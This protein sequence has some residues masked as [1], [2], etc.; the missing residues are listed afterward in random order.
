M[1]KLIVLAAVMAAVALGSYDAMAQCDG[2]ASDG[3]QCNGPAPGKT[4]G[5]VNAVVACVGGN[6]NGPAGCVCVA[7]HCFCDD[8]GTECDAAT[9][10]ETAA[11][12]CCAGGACTQH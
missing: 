12:A 5:A 1:K 4:A 9:C 11:A 2:T 6:A 8:T 3:T 7:G 10:T